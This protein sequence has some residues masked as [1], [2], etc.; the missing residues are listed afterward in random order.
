MNYLKNILGITCILL[1]FG[2]KENWDE[3]YNS[4]PETVN[5]NLWDAIQNDNNLSLFVQ[6]LKEFSYD[7]LIS[8]GDTYTLFVP[9][10]EAVTRLLDTGNISIA[11]LDYH[12][13]P[14][15]IQSVDITGKRK[16]QTLSEKFALF[17]NYSN[18]IFFDGIKLAFESP[19][20]LNGKYFIMDKVALPKPN[21]YEYYVEHNRILADYID[22]QDSII[23]DREKS[24]PIGFDEFG[25]TIYDTVSDIFNL[26]EEEF[27]PVREEFRFKTATIVFPNEEDYNNAL[28][29]IAQSLNTPNQNY[30]DIPLDWQYDI[31]IPQLLEHG[32]FENMLEE[33]DFMK[34]DPTDTLKLKNILGDSIIIDYMPV[35]KAICSNGY[36]Y[37][38]D[39][40]KIPDTLFTGSF[41]LEGEVLLDEVGINK[42]A[43]YEDIRVSS[44]LAF[45][46]I[47]EYIST[48]SNDSILKVNFTSGYKGKYSVAFDVINLFPR[49]YLMVIRTHMDIGGVY[50]IYVNNELVKSFDYY[51]YKLYWQIYTSVTGKRYKPEGSYN[52]FDCWVENIHDFGKTEI[53]F[54]YK[55][56]GRVRLNGLVIDYIDFIP[57]EKVE[58]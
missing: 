19:L 12:I 15:F 18:A 17:E 48:A 23:L 57:E 47:Q 56:P 26:F 29:V 52:I 14:H 25:N 2:C 33:S 9:D 51:Y 24:R 46:P 3:H 31:L 20:Y 37:N 58:Q 36:A 7:T 28:T 49:K 45:E 30:T 35:E 38:Y 39:N 42:F 34:E 11:I 53:R 44:D 13:S 43:W 10:N 6:Y 40:F 21:I 22:S 8:T 55:E 27:F 50:D 16:L 32:M 1:L 54:E 41:R 4:Q 5:I